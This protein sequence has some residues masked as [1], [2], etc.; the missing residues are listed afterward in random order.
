MHIEAEP[1]EPV[2]RNTPDAPRRLDEA[3]RARARAGGVLSEDGTCLV[4]AG[5]KDGWVH[6]RLAEDSDVSALRSPDGDLLLIA[7]SPSGH[8]VC[9]ASTEGG[10]YWILGEDF[11][12]PA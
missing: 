12:G 7:R 5:M 2:Q 3:W 4:A 9:A 11:P 6:V 10:D 1:V 8:R